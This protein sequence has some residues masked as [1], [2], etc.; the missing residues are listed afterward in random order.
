MNLN[1]RD[2]RLQKIKSVAS[3]NQKPRR[4]AYRLGDLQITVVIESF[5]PKAAAGESDPMYQ[6]KITVRKGRAVRV[7]QAVGDAD[8]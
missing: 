3:A 8:C 4:F 6:M 1:G 5:N 7:V 2:V